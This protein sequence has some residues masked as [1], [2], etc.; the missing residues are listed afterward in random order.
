MTSAESK[1]FS[2]VL[3]TSLFLCGS[4]GFQVAVFIAKV[5]CSKHSQFVSFFS[6]LLNKWGSKFESLTSEI[7]GFIVC[8]FAQKLGQSH[9]SLVSLGKRRLQKRSKPFFISPWLHTESLSLSL[10][11]SSQQGN[12]FPWSH[13][14]CMFQSYSPAWWNTVRIQDLC[15]VQL[16]HCQ[17]RSLDPGNRKHG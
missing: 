12:V 5:A 2:A 17:T 15:T 10:T 8:A 3:Q 13:T 11:L 7:P 14:G 16:R 9:I 1:C 4:I 6:L